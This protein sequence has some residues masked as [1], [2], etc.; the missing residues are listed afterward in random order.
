MHLTDNVQA[1]PT[2]LVATTS[3]VGFACTLSVKCIHGHHHFTVEPLR[4][5]LAVVSITPTNTQVS[6]DNTDEENMAPLD[7]S[8]EVSTSKDNS[9]KVTPEENTNSM[10]ENS[11]ETPQKKCGRPVS[12]CK[13]EDYAI[14]YLAYLMM[15]LF[16]NG[17]SCIETM[18]GMLGIAIASGNCTSWTTIGNWLGVAQ[19]KVADAVQKS[20]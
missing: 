10:S 6:E 14:N 11:N 3:N 17:I 4:V 20:I 7:E 13:I 2:L 5:Q 15:Q 18:L 9:V 16:G 12:S 1:K 19:Q 8:T